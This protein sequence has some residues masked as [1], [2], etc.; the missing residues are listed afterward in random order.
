MSNLKIKQLKQFKH[1]QPF[2]ALDIGSSKVCF[3][4]GQLSDQGELSVMGLGEVAHGGVS[5][6]AIVHIDATIKA[7]VQAKKEAETMAA[8]KVDRVWLSICGAH[9]RSFSSEGV[10]AVRNK[11]VSISDIKRVL[12]ATRM[13][14]LSSDEKVLHTLPQSFKVDTQ[15]G[16]E[17]PLGMFCVRLES[18]THIVVGNT[19]ALSNYIKCASKAG[20]KVESLALSALASA[21]AVLTEDEKKLG[22]AL[23]DIGAETTKVVCYLEGRVMAT[24]FL[25]LGGAYFTKDIAVGLRT[26]S[27]Q[28]EK[29]KK[30]HGC[31]LREMI[32][33][34]TFFP[35]EGN[36][37]KGDRKVPLHELVD[38]LFPRAEEFFVLLDQMLKGWKIYPHLGSGL[39]LT[40]GACLLPGFMELA[41]F[42]LDLSVRLG[43]PFKLKGLGDMLY[44][45]SYS[46]V[47]G[48]VQLIEETQKQDILTTSW[49]HKQPF[50][51]P[52][53][54]KT[55]PLMKLG[56]KM[57]TFLGEFL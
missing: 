4:I 17:N 1:Q 50:Y 5:K 42:D 23:V 43:I 16:I 30:E 39:V 56:S 34:N 38:I 29:I 8:C 10:V 9:I 45:P 55:N 46:T 44:D 20:L 31:I 36:H 26:S 12:D 22:V 33:E 49:R 51:S 41:E 11:E 53:F 54:F 32:R 14:R 25:P 24:G 6:G 47:L 57:K 19:T 48:L 2:A 13:V 28:A 27:Y 52:T 37:G 15:E 18:Y 7:I 35:I 21:Q 3:V 40:G